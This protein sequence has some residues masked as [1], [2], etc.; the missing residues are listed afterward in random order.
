MAVNATTTGTTAGLYRPSPGATLPLTLAGAWAT[1]EPLLRLLWDDVLRQEITAGSLL[2]GQMVSYRG[3]SVTER[4]DDYLSV[5]AF[6]A[7]GDGATDDTQA[8]KDALASAVTSGGAHLLIPD[9]TYVISE[10]LSVSGVG[11]SIVG[12]GPSLSRVLFQAPSGYFLTISVDDFNDPIELAGFS[13]LA[14]G[15]EATSGVRIIGNAAERLFRQRRHH[16]SG[17]A[18]T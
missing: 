17:A 12:D 3:R 18:D 16:G 2:T 7:K 11:V 4:L 10:A 8:F 9:G 13:V 1:D 5:K 14:F 6:G 15:Q